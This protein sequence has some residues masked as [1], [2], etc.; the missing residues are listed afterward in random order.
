MGNRANASIPL[1]PS[2]ASIAARMRNWGAIWINGQD[3]KA[4]G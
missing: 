3:P 2:I 1:W 4:P